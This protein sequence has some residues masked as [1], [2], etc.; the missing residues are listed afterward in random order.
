[1]AQEQKQPR[2]WGDKRY[3][4]FN[5]H[6]RQTFGGKVFK[7]ALDGGFTC[8]NRDGTFGDA[9]CIYCSGRGSGDFAGQAGTSLHEQFVQGRAMMQK[10]W[11]RAQYIA[12]FQAFSNTYA[13]LDRLKQVYEAGLAESGVVGLAIATRPDC[14]SPEVVDY[15]AELSRRTYLWLELGLQTIHRRTLDW[16]GRGHDEDQFLQAVQRLQ[17]RD[18]R[19]CAHLILGLPGESREDMLASAAAVAALPVQGVK[20]HLLHVLRGTRLAEEFL[21]RPFELLSREDYISLVTDILEITPP[22]KIILR[23]T[24]D[25]APN[26]LLAPVWSRKKWEVLNAIDAE[27]IRRNAWQGCRGRRS[28]DKE[29]E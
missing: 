12:Y 6:L 25:G 20:Y 10:K 27:L 15:L 21:R 28:I 29:M 11:P 3:H 16:I 17:R 1:L 24:G 5:W 14:L 13:P 8:P 9:G 4:T 19:I 22:D 18:I 23:L 26:D 7:V 2:L